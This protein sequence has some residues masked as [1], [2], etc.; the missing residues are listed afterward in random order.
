MEQGNRDS[1]D[2][3][4]S[5]RKGFAGFIERLLRRSQKAMHVLALF[6]LYA[7][8]TLCL[9]LAIAPGL[10]L[11]RYVDRTTEAQHA[12][13]HYVSIGV[14]GAAAYFL[15]GF[16]L[17]LVVPFINWLLRAKLQPWRGQYYSLESVR[18]YVHNGLVYLVRYTFLEFITPT[19]FNI[20][21]FRA[22]GMKIGEGTQLNTTW[23]SDPSL[24]EMGEKVTVGG[25]ATIIA[26]YGMKGLLVIAP[27]K[28]GSRVTIGIKATVMG[29]V[30]IGDGSTVL[31]HSVVLPK[32]KIPPGE[33]WGGIPAQKIERKETTAEKN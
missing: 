10:F 6:P 24:I 28:I 23:I 19:P 25:S 26:H 30:E 8:A 17:I 11:F 1:V 5:S 12:L 7:I 32:T 21:F 33:V 29:G 15:Y 18:W 31:P 4:D 13:L 14:A 27:V 3:K 16:M 9:G 2:S 22:M 20:F